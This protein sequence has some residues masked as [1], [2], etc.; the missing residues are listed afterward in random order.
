MHI[1]F[2]PN[3]VQLI[4]ACYPPTAALLTS[5]PDYRPN[6]QELSR[7]TYYAV[8][9]TG[10]LNKLGAE[11]EKRIKVEGRKAQAGNTR[12]R[13]S[14]LI[15]LAIMRALATECRRDIPL[16][17]PS[18][19]SAVDATLAALP[20]DLEVSAKA[21]T[22]FTTWTTFTD[23]RLIGVDQNATKDYMSILDKFSAM[24]TVE[25]R[26]TD[27]EFRNRT[28]LVGLA[29]LTGAVT[30]EALYS[31]TS[32][33]QQVPIIVSALFF[34]IQGVDLTALESESNA[35]KGKASSPYLAE[36][37][38]RPPNERRAHS[39]HLHVDGERG[40]SATDV[41]SACLRA[42][43]S[44]FEHS[45]GSNVSTIMQAALDSINQRNGWQ[46]VEH[47]RWLA[48]KAT[49]WTQY[50]YRY[51]VP[52]CLVEKLVEDQDISTTTSM[53]TSLA[54]M[55]TAIFTSPTPLIN[56]STSDVVS[57]LVTLV[58]R[59]TAVNVVDPLLPSLTECIASLGTHVYYSDQIQ[60]LT[61]EIVG[62][63]VTVDSNGISAREQESNDA[64][65]VVALRHLIASL[66]GLLRAP[67]SHELMKETDGNTTSPLGS[68]KSSLSMEH[69][70]RSSLDK[71]EGPHRTSRRSKVAPETW[72]DTV[73]LL[74]DDDYSVR[75]DYAYALS[76]FIESEMTKR[77]EYIDK[78]GVRRLR[79]LAEGPVRQVNNIIGMLYGDDASRLLHA[80]HVHLYVLATAVSF[81]PRSQS[82]SPT[83]SLNEGSNDMVNVVPPTPTVSVS[84]PP[85]EGRE[86]SPARSHQG[87]PS[88]SISLNARSRR[89]SRTAKMLLNTPTCLSPS[90]VPLATA[91]DYRNMLSVLTVVHE[92]L[93]VRGMLAGVPFLMSLDTFTRTPDDT[94][95]AISG[96]I[97]AIREVLARVW[98]VIGKIWECAEL[99]Q[100]AEYAIASIPNSSHLLPA[101]Q[102]PG[103]LLLTTEQPVPISPSPGS[104]SGVDADAA[105]RALL[106]NQHM[107]D[108][109]GMNREVLEQ[110]LTAP[111]TTESAWKDS[112]EPQS[113]F[114]PLRGD[115]ASARL[116]VAPALMHIENMSLQSLTRSTRGVG[117]SDLREALQGRSSMS[118]P[119]LVN[120]APSI[121]T[122][123][124]APPGHGDPVSSRLVPARSRVEKLRLNGNPTEVRDVLNKLRIGKQVGGSTMLKA[125]FPALQRPEAKSSTFIPPYKS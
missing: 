16:L 4:A 52:M 41:T 104:W 53:H 87:R 14:L 46:D 7:L 64:S 5:G 113:T 50:Q 71:V 29:A 122:L 30:S 55:I 48:S 85:A 11:I 10:K 103:S 39:I 109:I 83:R 90:H 32:F 92:Q 9:K 15:S 82:S 51:A 67:G 38:A 117:V 72:Q 98:L 40:P 116:K 13:A 69:P 1:P 23:G 107:L 45:T 25:S 57:N 89:Q 26:L 19:L 43:S 56:L 106:E 12:M 70:I 8:N 96:H 110:R 86:E 95:V 88:L 112:M 80:V 75:A 24:S 68:P 28:H 91:S 59:R 84:A 79:P 81:R 124:H 77:G 49:E 111:W 97:T 119:A 115:G 102:R 31:S 54:A 114:D 94:D 42:L 47:C 44:L 60:D 21:A 105:L 33:R 99:V 123:D 36:F 63:L 120:K 35:L 66:V 101:A 76:F 20:S 73:N 18:L 118:N 6:S 37:R 100:M 58:L 2:T 34:N 62:R 74:C 108:A 93:P 65:R 3:H 22:L 61:G 78:D 27:H 125:S 121:S 17:T